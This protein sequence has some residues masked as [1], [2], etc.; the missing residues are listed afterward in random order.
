MD[1]DAVEKLHGKVALHGDLIG[2]VADI[3][4]DRGDK[5]RALS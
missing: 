4:P 1:S 2:R 3:V 5:A